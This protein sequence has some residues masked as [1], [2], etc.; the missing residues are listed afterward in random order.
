[1]YCTIFFSGEHALARLV[2]RRRQIPKTSFVSSPRHVVETV[3][4]E[5]ETW[6][7]AKHA[8]RALQQEQSSNNKARTNKAQNL[9]I[10]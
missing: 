1:V 9:Q 10:L 2:V 8:T 7:K 3:L 4:L 6:K 5:K